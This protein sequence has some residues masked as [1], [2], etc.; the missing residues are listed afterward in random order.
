MSQ[1]V[2]LESALT[3]VGT[4]SPIN[5]TYALIASH[6]RSTFASLL[7]AP[8]CGRTEV[9]DEVGSLVVCHR[10]TKIKQRK[11]VK[12]NKGEIEKST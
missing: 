9:Q 2:Q 1:A 7:P 4:S 12:R 3:S 6:A 8:Q 5:K 11:R 10:T